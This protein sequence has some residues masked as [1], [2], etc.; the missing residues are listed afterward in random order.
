MKNQFALALVGLS[1]MAMSNLASAQTHTFPSQSFNRL[2]P[3]HV[4]GDR[5]FGGNGPDVKASARLVLTNLDRSIDLVATLDAKETRSNWSHARGTFR[6]RIGTVPRGYE[7]KRIVSG[8]RSSASYRDHDHHIDRP[9]IRGS[10]VR[11]FEIMGDTKGNDIGNCTSD[12][13]FMN[14]H[15]NS[16]RVELKR[17]VYPTRQLSYSPKPIRGLCPKHVGGDREFDGHGPDVKAS[18]SLR[19]SHDRRSIIA[20]MSLDAKETKRNWSHAKGNFRRAIYQAPEGYRVAKIMSDTTSHT[21]YR[22]T[23]HAIDRPHV[24]G[25]K[26]VRTFEIKGDTKGR[27]IGNCTNDDVFMNV[28]FNPLKVRL[29]HKSAG[30]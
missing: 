12:D 7:I 26:L 17:T 28:H 9:R 20:T 6:K 30:G 13:V 16:I 27:D 29:I 25:G 14:V 11:E 24:A 8:T 4:S 18:A 23:D 10:L 5:E 15:T 22:D 2:C 1:A 21:R 19:I 3:G